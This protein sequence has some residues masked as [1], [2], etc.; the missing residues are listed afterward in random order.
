MTDTRHYVTHDTTP[1]RSK[2]SRLN[3]NFINE[4]KN[5]EKT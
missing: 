4:I 5:D 1:T 3:E 2:T